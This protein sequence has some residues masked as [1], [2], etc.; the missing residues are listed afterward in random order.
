MSASARDPAPVLTFR[1]VECGSHG[2][3]NFTLEKGQSRSIILADKDLASLER[4]LAGESAPVPG[5]IRI[6]GVPPARA[7]AWSG[8]LAGRVTRTF[9]PLFGRGCWL[10]Q[11]DIEENVMI[12]A[13]MGG[14]KLRDV[15]QR[16]RE[17]AMRLSLPSLPRTRRSA[18]LPG[19]LTICQWVR[20]FLM[21]KAGLFLMVDALRDATSDAMDALMMECQ[22]RRREGAAF[23]W[24]LP[25]GDSRHAALLENTGNPHPGKG[26]DV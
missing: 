3:L 24:L 2:L 4:T 11:L 1:H 19:T 22:A 26:G 12:A 7:D 6:Y 10:E 14:E 21:N 20:A 16:S 15:R 8:P 23:L 17:L 25:E 9:S 13:L 5:E 18:T